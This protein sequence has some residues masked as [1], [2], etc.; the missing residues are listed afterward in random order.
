MRV[1]SALLCVPVLLAAPMP[2]LAGD[3]VLTG[4][5]P[6]WVTPADLGVVDVETDPALLIADYQHRLEHGV[7]HSYYD[8]AVRIDNP[9]SLM[10][11]NTLNLGWLPDKGDLTVHRMEIHRGSEVIDLLAEGA[12]F[13]V[14]RREQGLE[15]R[16]LDG[17][18]TATLAI[19]G[20]RVGDVLRTA[21]S[22]TVDD[23]ALGDEVQILQYLGSEPWRV[24]LGRTIVS[25]PQDEPIK[26]R[27]EDPA[28]LEDPELRDGYRYLTVG[29]PLPERKAVPADAPYRYQ[30]PTVLRVGSFADWSE[31]SRVMAPHFAAAAEVDERGAVASQAAAIMKQASD[32][33]E[34]AALAT[35][36]VQ[37]EVSYLLN[38]LAGGNY[39]P[40]GAEFTWEKRYGDC[41]AKT[42]LLLALLH[43]M[44]IDAEPMLVST[45]GGDA[46]PDL[47]P[48]PGDFDHVIVRARIGDVDYWL[49]GTST[50]TRLANIAD[51][52]PFHYALPLRIGGADLVAIPQRD[53][54]QPDMRMTGTMDHS[55][56]IDFPQLFELTMEVSGP[57]GAMLES[58]AD[59]NDPEMLRRLAGGFAER[60]G[61]EGGVLTSLG[62]AYDKQAAVGRLTIEGIAAPS[63]RW[64]NGRLV[65]DMDAA[66]EEPTF[67]PDRARLDWR[68]IPVATPGPSYLKLEVSMILP[69]EGRG[70]SLSGSE[71]L[72]A[73]V[74][75]TRF[76]TTATLAGDTVS[77]R[78][79]VWQRPGEV[80]PAD[81]AEAKRRALRIEAET[82]ELVTP[83]E[84]TWRWALGDDERRSRAA[85][86]LAA[87]D[88][89]IEFAVEDDYNPLIQKAWFLHSIYEYEAALEAYDELIANAPSDWS[90]LQRSNVLL[91]LGRGDDAIADLEAAYELDPS[92]EIAFALAKE[93]AYAGRGD[94]AAELLDVL[95]VRD[96]ERSG[97][98]DARAVVSGLQGDTGGALSLLA[99]VVA[100][101][102]EDSRALNA[103]CWFRGLFN[104]ALERAMDGCTRAVERADNPMAALDS[105]AMVQFRLGNYEAAIAD[106]DAVLKMAPAVPDSRYLRGIVRLKKGDRGGRE[107]IETALRMSP[108]LQEF[109]RRHGVAP[110]L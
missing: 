108:R 14:L 15:A 84:V 59:T 41:K 16:L 28:G 88:R 27:A 29:L 110:E 50:A 5:V 80:A 72:E 31:L 70:F 21:Y 62:V 55:A 85:P 7:V 92:N 43:R 98:A 34:R 2:A 45:R 82:A 90:Y 61:I 12:E 109:Y 9:Q 81:V 24:G 78:S 67:N 68:D 30:R 4:A 26:W 60:G 48:V 46:L 42:V 18:L 64:E 95:P 86:I 8:T 91:A 36:L 63:F 40:Q 75:N 56:G 100:D 38:G 69:Q 39:L 107:D 73:D 3:T 87:Y 74:A 6:A 104:V 97:H 25:W 22:I 49:D 32:P 11:H 79:D 19:P 102:P 13:D 54:A 83:S 106:L 17:E 96:D 71:K 10:D 51:V 89:A 103:E 23:Q 93:L 101:K 76:A 47:L 99:E 57:A 94:E 1:R 65:V 53:K 52:P 33:L 37:D 77:I 20:L 44:G 66:A 35:R 105:R 58:L